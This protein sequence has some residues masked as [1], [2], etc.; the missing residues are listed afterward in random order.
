MEIVKKEPIPLAVVADKLE[1][2]S[3]DITLEYEQK[4]TLEYAKKFAIGKKKTKEMLKKLTELGIPDE[5]A[6]A[7]VNVAPKEPETVKL[8]GVWKGVEI[9]EDQAKEIVEL[10]K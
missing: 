10:F 5:V 1:K 4:N 7:I 9:G 8:I 6:V 3:K 2:A